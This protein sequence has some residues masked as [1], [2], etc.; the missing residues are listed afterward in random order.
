MSHPADLIKW[1]PLSIPVVVGLLAL[2]AAQL[3]INTNSRD[4]RQVES[5][6]NE[7]SK[8]IDVLRREILTVSNKIDIEVLRLRSLISSF[9]SKSDAHF[10]RM[11]SKIDNM[12]DEEPSK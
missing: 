6:V 1:A 7:N 12:Q 3:Q 5:R 4:L 11:M 8:E 9:E 2:G 10:E